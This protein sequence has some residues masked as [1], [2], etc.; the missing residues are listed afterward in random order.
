MEYYSGDFLPE[1]IC[2]LVSASLTFVYASVDQV[3][4]RKFRNWYS[5]FFSQKPF[6]LFQAAGRRIFQ[7]WYFPLMSGIVIWPVVGVT[8]PV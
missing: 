8:K 6:H 7:N 4:G 5:V 2:Y 1:G 3:V